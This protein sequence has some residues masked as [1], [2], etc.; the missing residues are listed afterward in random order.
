[1]AAGRPPEPEP[2]LFLFFTLHSITSTDPFA[3]AAAVRRGAA[4]SA[5]WTY[6]AH[7]PMIEADG[8]EQRRVMAVVVEAET[9]EAMAV[10]G[11]GSGQTVGGDKVKEEEDILFFGGGSRVRRKISAAVKYVPSL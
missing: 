6:A 2:L 4:S 7:G 1:M 3:V 8:A 10:R 9:K 11:G 5:R